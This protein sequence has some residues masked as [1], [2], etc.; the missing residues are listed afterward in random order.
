MTTVDEP[1]HDAHDYNEHHFFA[2]G[3]MWVPETDLNETQAEIRRLRTELTAARAVV[4]AARAQAAKC[5]KCG[6]RGW[7]WSDWYDNYKY[8]CSSCFSSALARLDAQAAEK[9]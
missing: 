9:S 2:Q 5:E 6:G 7:Y 1:S 3:R 4:E 8:T